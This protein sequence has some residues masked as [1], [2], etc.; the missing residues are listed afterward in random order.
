V[1]PLQRPK[2]FTDEATDGLAAVLAQPHIM[3]GT[4]L[5]RGAAVDVKAKVVGRDVA[6]LIVELLLEILPAL[7]IVGEAKVDGDA[8]EP[9]TETKR[10]SQTLGSCRLAGQHYLESYLENIPLG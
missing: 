3:G 5:G 4:A 6:I 7:R 10:I 2:R 1:V 9:E 8:V